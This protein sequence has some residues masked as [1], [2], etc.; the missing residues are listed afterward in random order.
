MPFYSIS[1]IISIYKYRTSYKNCK[2]I[3]I[4]NNVNK[5]FKAC[6]RIMNT[7][8]Q[9]CNTYGHNSRKLLEPLYLYYSF[10][11]FILFL[12][13]NKMAFHE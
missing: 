6:A 5:K 4:M 2:F 10:F 1:K 7:V 12:M 8:N 3:R 13:M 11:T 9:K